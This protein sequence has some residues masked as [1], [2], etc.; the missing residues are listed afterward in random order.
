MLISQTNLASHQG[1]SHASSLLSKGEVASGRSFP[2][3]T[4]CRLQRAKRVELTSHDV[5]DL[6][7][8]LIK[9]L[10]RL[11]VEHRPMP[12]RDDGFASLCYAGKTF[13]HFHND[14]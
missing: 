7:V 2:H 8:Q 3:R 9:R 13:A 12:G 6:R 11:G 14:R 10:A 4:H 1:P 5:S